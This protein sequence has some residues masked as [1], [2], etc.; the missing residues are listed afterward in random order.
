MLIIDDKK[1]TFGGVKIL[2]YFFTRNVPPGMEICALKAPKDAVTLVS[3]GED[4]FSGRLDGERPGVAGKSLDENICLL[5]MP[6]A[7]PS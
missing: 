4:M 3:A 5:C 1:T 2:T 7:I 6:G